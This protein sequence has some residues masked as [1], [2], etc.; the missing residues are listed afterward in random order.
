METIRHALDEDRFTTPMAHRRFNMIEQQI[1]PYGVLNQPV[2]NAIAATPR[3]LF[4]DERYASIAYAQLEVPIIA[5]GQDSGETMLMP[6]LEAFFAEQLMLNPEDTVLEIG[7][8]SGYQAAILSRL[9]SNVVSV[10]I[11]PTIAAQAQENL[12]KAGINNVT[13]EVGDA[14]SG[15]KNHEFDAICVTGSLRSIPDS[16]RYQLRSGG[17]LVIVT[18]AAP[19]MTAHRITRESA[20]NFMSESLVETCIPPLK[21]EVFSSF[22]F[23]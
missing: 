2:L 7:T 18:G 19:L 10:E 9:C 15:W 20:A 21:G 6:Q 4:I 23:S 8:G 13:V 14:H 17:R 11:N 16:L 5:D 12:A 22:R 3:E 1:R